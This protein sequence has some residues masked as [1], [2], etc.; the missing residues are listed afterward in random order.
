VGL[1]AEPPVENAQP[2]RIP[3]QGGRG[4]P[5]LS[6]GLLAL[7]AAAVT[8]PAAATATAAT[9]LVRSLAALGGGP[10]NRRHR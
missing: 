9:G 3:G 1:V 5:P 4:G 10:A 2:G 6:G 8:A 7:A